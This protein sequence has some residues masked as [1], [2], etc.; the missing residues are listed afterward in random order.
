MKGVPNH[1]SRGKRE[2]RYVQS[3]PS[4]LELVEPDG[5]RLT[6]LNHDGWS[7]MAGRPRWSADDSR[8]AVDD[9]IYD[10]ATWRQV[11]RI[12]FVPNSVGWSTGGRLVAGSNHG[13]V[14]AFDSA[15]GD[16]VGGVLQFYEGDAWLLVGADGHYRCSP[17]L[18]KHLVY[19]TRT[20]D[21]KEERLTPEEFAKKYG[22]KNDP[23]K[24]SRE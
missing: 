4:Q 22:W 12:P 3:Q 1:A 19:V 13:R 2:A 10:T 16:P 21:G 9:V 15:S 17:G 18:E 20:A 24:G 11:C 14:Q 23:A 5:K 8:L 6:I 7:A